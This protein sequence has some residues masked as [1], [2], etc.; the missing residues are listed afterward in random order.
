MN[1]QRKARGTRARRKPLFLAAILTFVMVLSACGGGG[2]AEP[3]SSNT[4]TSGGTDSGGKTEKPYEVSLFYPGTP[5]KDVALVEAE[6]NKY[7]EPKIGATLKINAIDWGQWDN[8]LNLMISSGEKSDIIFTAAWQNY[9]VN[10][11]KS[12]FLPLNDLLESHG[13]EIVKNLDPAFLEGSQV[14]GKNYGVPS[15]KE[16]AATRGVLVRKDLLEKYKLDITNVKTW[17]DLEPLLK[18]IKENEPGVTPFYMSNSTGNGLLD[19]LDWDYLGDASVPG[20]I[21]KMG[22]ETTVL[23]EVETPEFKEAAALARKWYEAG[24]INSDAATS[25]VFP[26]DQA[27]AGKVFMWTDG[28]KPGKDKEEES[29]VGFPLTQIEMTQPTITT[30]DTSGAMLA[31]SRTSENPEKAMQVINLL[32]SDPVVNNL[33]NF[34]IE[35][36]HYVKK[37]GSDNIISLPEGT[38][39]NNR[40]YN[41]GAQWQLGNQFLN[42]LWDNEDPEK[43]DKF[44]DF[45]A[46]GV[47]SPALGFTFNSQPVK[48]EIAAVNNVNKQFKPAL[49]SGAVD[50]NEMIPKYAEKLKA[51]G[52]DKIIAE[53]QKQLD[54]FLAKK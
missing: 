11:A 35:G 48:N 33:L 14:D 30:G 5:Q 17:A 12:A 1:Q 44:K 32:H 41:P 4:G 6:I 27:K 26:K 13:Q 19:N 45:N 39:P 46:R 3:V 24:Y 18:T 9:T 8:K 28:M 15:N 36:T 31:I 50:P 53:K 29:Y 2:E 43:W 52:I 22:S 7:M 16:L 38:D 51:A 10:V 37:E 34:G 20:V 47:K 42:Y 21:R 25:T 40:T 49:T 23:N 54:A